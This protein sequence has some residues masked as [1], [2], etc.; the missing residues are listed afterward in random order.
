MR[1]RTIVSVALLM[2]VIGLTTAACGNMKADPN[3]YGFVDSRSD[4]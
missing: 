4:G 3:P 2:A 1:R